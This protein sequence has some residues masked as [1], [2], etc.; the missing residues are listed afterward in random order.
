[1]LYC[2]YQPTKKLRKN[3]SFADGVLEVAV[4][5]KKAV[6]AGSPPGCRWLLLRCVHLPVLLAHAFASSCRA[7]STPQVLMDAEGKVVSSTV[8]RGVNVPTMGEGSTVVVGNWEVSGAWAHTRAL[9]A[10]L[11]HLI[12]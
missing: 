6:G 5:S 9:A 2:K 12:S 11:M 8:L 4:V 1:M 10:L 3:K 7:A